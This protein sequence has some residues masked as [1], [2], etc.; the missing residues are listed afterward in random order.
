M[1]K[2]LIAMV[3]TMVIALSV[4]ATPVLAFVT[5]DT[6]FNILTWN[7]NPPAPISIDAEKF[8][9]HEYTQEELI[10]YVENRLAGDYV[11]V[12]KF[13]VLYR[14]DNIDRNEKSEIRKATERLAELTGGTADYGIKVSEHNAALIYIN[15]VA[16][17]DMRDAM[18]RV[19]NDGFYA[20]VNIALP[21]SEKDHAEPFLYGD[22]NLDHK[23]N[24]KDYMMLKRY[25]EKTF[26]KKSKGFLL[27]DIND[28]GRVDAQ[29]YLLL[30]CHILGTYEI[31]RADFVWYP[32]DE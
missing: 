25:A 32:F 2:R 22:V 16:I 14:F 27:S 8:F 12:G 10:A 21:G 9:N 11:I 19:L 20:Y 29:D 1:K 13:R 28:D 17:D 31:K 4:L 15:D 3:L 24:A 23:V 26:D 6:G 7:P 30:K 5:I 18:I